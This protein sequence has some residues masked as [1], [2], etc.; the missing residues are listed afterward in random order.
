MIIFGDTMTTV[1]Y[2]EIFDVHSGINLEVL[3]KS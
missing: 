3:I 1:V 2:E